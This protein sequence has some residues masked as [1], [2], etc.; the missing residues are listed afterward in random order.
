ML[1]KLMYMLN[2]KTKKNELTF[3]AINHYLTNQHFLYVG[4]DKFYPAFNGKI[5]LFKYHFGSGAYN[6]N[7]RD[8]RPTEPSEQCEEQ[9]PIPIPAPKPP[10]PGPV[11][12]PIP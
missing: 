12:R 11:P 5:S 4:R 7:Y 6:P 1:R 2:S 8:I 3:T 10:M 9:I